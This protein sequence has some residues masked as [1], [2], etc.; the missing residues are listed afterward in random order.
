M[1]IEQMAWKI[2]EYKFAYYQYARL[3]PSWKDEMVISDVAYDALEAHY[4]IKCEE[5]DVEPSAADMVDFNF[6]KASC[7]LVALKL[8]NPKGISFEQV[9]KI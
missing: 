5:E 8:S 4:R 6:D 3:H 1:T 9:K 2:L 7:R